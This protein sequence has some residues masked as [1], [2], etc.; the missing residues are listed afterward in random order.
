MYAI[1]QDTIVKQTILSL[2]F[3]LLTVIN[4]NAQSNLKLDHIFI[5]VDTT[6]NIHQEL[7]KAGL[8][9]AKKWTTPHLQQG[10]IGEFFFFL[11]FYLE[12]LY[13][14]N[15]E[16][17]TQNIL[18]FGSDYVKRSKW[19][20]NNSFHF[21]LGFVLKDSTHKIPFETHTYQAKWMGKGNALKMAKT[22]EDLQEPLVFVEPDIW[23]NQ[24]FENSTELEKVKN[25]DVKNYR[26][27]RLGI[28]KL[29]KVILIV[30][31]KEKQ[32]SKTLKALK[33]VENIEI[34]AGK[35][36]LIIL[37]FDGN[38]QNKVINSATQL[39]LIIKY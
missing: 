31:K 18:N 27:N 20:E 37:E 12:F 8:T 19:K 29:T 2:C 26:T 21:G 24:I 9:H 33:A 34:R 4:I 30:P 11:N 17:A 22:N 28:E 10:T 6:N 3:S 5:L 39:H 16:E 13:V 23:A 15:E 25:T 1:L 36:P 38:K 35:K 7:E 32:F 14:S